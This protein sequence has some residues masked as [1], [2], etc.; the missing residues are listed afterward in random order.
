MEPVTPQQQ[1][2]I[3][4]LRRQAEEAATAPGDDQGIFGLIR[5]FLDFFFNI[6]L[7]GEDAPEEGAAPEPPQSPAQRVQS[8]IRAG[9][10][11]IDSNAVPNWRAFQRERQSETVT[12]T[13]PVAGNATI[14]SEMD[15]HRR[16]P[17]TGVVRAHNG[18][19]FGAR[20]DTRNPDILASADGIVLWSGPQ[21]GYGNTVILG[22]ADGSQTLYAHMT[23]ARMPEIGST[24]EQGA[25]IGVMGST[26]VSTGNHLHYEQ[27]QNGNYR[28]PV[29]NG[30][31]LTRGTQLNGERATPQ[32]PPQPAPAPEAAPQ[33]AA[34]Q[35]ARPASAPHPMQRLVPEGLARLEDAKEIAGNVLDDANAQL[36]RANR[37]IQNA[38]TAAIGWVFRG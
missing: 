34:A 33:P 5:Q 11:L 23:G 29:V 21:R 9:R 20:G 37:A 6:F 17:V 3:E 16:H 24:V 15:P 38:R 4:R 1:A 26:G 22:H 32:R 27:I 31:P 14:T 18:A 35:P 36:Q 10:K 12:H 8:A 13:S 30:V 25:V 7:K 19:D 2:E 28:T